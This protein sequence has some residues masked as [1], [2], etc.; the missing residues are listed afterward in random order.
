MAKKRRSAKKSAKRAPRA[1]KGNHLDAWLAM[2][3]LA[4]CFLLTPWGGPWVAILFLSLGV[5]I[6][7]MTWTDPNME[8]PTLLMVALLVI[9]V[10]V[11]STGFTRLAALNP[12][13][14]SFIKATA[15]NVITLVAPAAFLAVLKEMYLATK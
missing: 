11:L 5:L 13:V 8:Q 14:A 4:L 10:S 15:V 12:I 6:G 2:F 3:G 1:K 7:F 9:A